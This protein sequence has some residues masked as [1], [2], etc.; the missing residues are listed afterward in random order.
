[1]KRTLLALTF[2]AS[3]H[4]PC[5]A[6][7]FVPE[8]LYQKRYDE[9]LSAA[10]K[11]CK[12]NPK[13]GSLL[14]MRARC[15]YHLKK[16]DAAISDL[17]RAINAPIPA[18]SEAYKWRYA[19]YIE[20]G[21]YDKAYRD[22][23][24]YLNSNPLDQSA[25]R[26]IIALAKRVP[27][28][29]HARDFVSKLSDTYPDCSIATMVSEGKY[30]QAEPIITR[31]L[32]KSLT[33]ERRKYFLDRRE[34]CYAAM[35]DYRKA[36]ADLNELITLYEKDKHRAPYTLYLR[37]A[38]VKTA[39]NQHRDAAVDLSEVVNRNLKFHNLRITTDDLLF[40]RASSY[41]KSKDYRKAIADYDAILR[42]DATEE[43]AYRL[44]G[45]CHAALKEYE[46]AVKDYSSAISNDNE[47][48]GSSYLS[49]S[50]VYAKMG[51]TKEAAADK[52]MAEKL[53]YASK[54]E[55]N[56]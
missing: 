21:Q 26:D 47:S 20:L 41:L 17:N 52:R 18:S 23:E 30:R 29:K 6:E 50:L 8:L 55:V 46:L 56:K 40:R 42:I 39:L 43:E 45:D 14:L 34:Y 37:R 15:K 51:K 36:L 22:C 49:R 28:D 7:P 31:M 27:N 3:S 24:N 12:E 2:I 4:V 48:A 11:R 16:Y 9:A 44:R 53:G 35:S 25:H 33:D 1:M 54:S 10:D 13:Y 19:C 38:E 5:G 32:K